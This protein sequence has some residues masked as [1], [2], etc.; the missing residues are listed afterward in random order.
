MSKKRLD[1]DR[2]L[3]ELSGQSVFFQKQI[4]NNWEVKRSNAQRKDRLEKTRLKKKTD[5]DHKQP[6]NRDTMQPC[7]HDTVVSRYHDT[8]IEMLRKAVKVIGKEAATYRFSI[9]EKR[10]I[11][12]LVYAYKR[13]G[14]RTSENEITRIAVNFVLRDNQESRKDGILERVLRALNT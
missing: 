10:A 2:V 1:K 4:P 7:N 13:R 11:A 14:I 3:N 8:T 9:D 12:D 5:P 6:S